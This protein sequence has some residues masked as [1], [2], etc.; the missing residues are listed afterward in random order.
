MTQDNTE[1]LDKEGDYDPEP[2]HSGLAFIRIELY[3]DSTEESYTEAPPL[4][5]MGMSLH[6]GEHYASGGEN[7]TA[8]EAIHSFLDHHLSGECECLE[9]N[10]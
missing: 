3:D 6:E 2:H 10:E 7:V 1:E 5:S 9:E 8:E 4:E